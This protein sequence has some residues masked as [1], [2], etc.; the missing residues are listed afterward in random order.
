MDISAL[1]TFIKLAAESQN[2]AVSALGQSIQGT[3]L[4]PQ[5]TE[6]N[7]DSQ[8][9]DEGTDSSTKDDEAAI[10]DPAF[11]EVT[12]QTDAEKYRELNSHK[13][14][15]VWDDLVTKAAGDAK[16]S[17]SCTLVRVPAKVKQAIEEF[18]KSIPV[19][20]L[21]TEEE[22]HGLEDDPHITVL[23]GTHTNDGSVIKKAI[24]DNFSKSTL[25]ITLGK[26]SLFDNPKFDVLKMEVV[27][28][29]L[30]ELNAAMKK[31]LPFTSDYEGYTPHC[32][33]AYLKKGKA[34][35][36]VDKEVST[37][38]FTVSEYIFSDN[39]SKKETF[40]LPKEKVASIWEGLKSKYNL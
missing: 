17:Y 20:D 26:T 39:N 7:D 23:Y 9:K 14:A 25:A 21:Y 4:N 2:P 16:R 15:S 5:N 36:F 19:G 28:K 38:S 1:S 33:V 34:A 32:T 11:E 37:T 35:P 12:Q 27:S 13:L 29:D 24:D 6:S 10:L 22:G 31:A 18:Q 8:V 3:E 40:T 30:A